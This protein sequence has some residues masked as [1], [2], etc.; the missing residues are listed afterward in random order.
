[1]VESIRGNVWNINGQS[2]IADQAQIDG[3]VK[4][5]SAVKFEGYYDATGKFIVTKVEVK[6]VDNRSTIGTNN[7]DGGS[8]NSGSSS[9]SGGNN[10]SNNQTENN[11]D[12]NNQTDNNSGSNNQTD[13]NQNDTGH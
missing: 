10:N 6:S 1:M 2:V 4:V 13:N 5:G 11:S 7:G 8:G 9:D 3:A 12:S